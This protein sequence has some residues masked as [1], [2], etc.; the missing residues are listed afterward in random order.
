MTAP[1]TVF[2]R[3]EG[4]LQAWGDTSKFVIRRSMEAPTKSGVLGLICCA[5]GLSRAAARERLPELNTLAMGVRI[6]RPGTL[7]WDY[8]TVG[9]KIGVLRADGKGIK[10]TAS[11]G[12]IET[13][14]TRREYLADASFLVALQGDPALVAAVAGAL[15]SPKWP[16]F[17][18]R[19]SCPAGVPVLARPADGESWTNPG[20]HDDL[21]AALDAVRWGPRYDDDAPRDAQRRTLDSISL[22]TLNEWRPA[23]DD[24]IDAAEAEVWY[25]APVCFDPPVHEPRLVIRSSVTVSIGDPLLHRTPAPPRP[26]AGYRDAEWTSEAIVD[27]VDEVTGEVTQEP[28]GARPRRLRRDKGLCVFCKNTATTVQH[29]TYRRAGG[30][31]RQVDLRALCRLCHDAVTMIEYGYGMGLDRIDPSD[32]RW[33][34]DILRTRGEILRFRSEETRRRALRDAPERVRDEQL[35]QKAG[36]V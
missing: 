32:E 13:L 5:M 36:E 35:E 22:D 1:N 26:R 29:V 33:R 27:V 18:G 24:D 31:E 6:D 20:A 21:K 3:L 17:L 14:I 8:H 4:P 25:D 16:V 7:C 15:A 12:E 28:R 34:D 11:T 23:S 9:A 30:D 10:R 19:K 2:V